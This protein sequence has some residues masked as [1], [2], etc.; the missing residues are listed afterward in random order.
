M[1]IIPPGLTR[2]LQFFLSGPLPCPYLAGQIERKLFTRLSDDAAAN[3]E[4]ARGFP[5]QP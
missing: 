1:S 3:M 4:I 2:Q 5:P